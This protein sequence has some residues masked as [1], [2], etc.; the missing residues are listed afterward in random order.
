MAIMKHAPKVGDVFIRVTGTRLEKF[1]EFDFSINDETLTVELVMPMGAFREFCDFY[2]ASVVT[3]DDQAE[4][5][6]EKLQWRSGMPGLYRP[7]VG[8]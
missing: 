7:P 3:V 2:Q 8:Q 1:V 5:A 4:K 6:F